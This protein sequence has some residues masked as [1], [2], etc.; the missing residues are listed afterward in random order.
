[1]GDQQLEAIAPE[2][3]RVQ[4]VDMCSPATGIGDLA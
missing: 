2:R 1:M 4:Q 3:E